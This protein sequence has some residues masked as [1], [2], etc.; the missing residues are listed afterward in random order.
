MDKYTA[1]FSEYTYQTTE[2]ILSYFGLDSHQGLSAQQVKGNKS[3]Y[4]SNVL[5]EKHTTLW[6][7]LWQ[8][9]NSL[10]V[11]IFVAIGILSLCLG[12]L[13]NAL[14]IFS[15]VSVNLFFGFYQEYS[16]SKA[17]ALLKKYL[18]SYVKVRRDGHDITIPSENIVVGDLVIIDSGD[19]LFA[20]I[21][22]IQTN[23]L[24]I[25]Q[26]VLTGESEAIPKT[27]AC[28]E[29]KETDIYKAHNIGFTGTTIMSGSAI[30]IVFAVGKNTTLGMIVEPNLEIVRESELVNSTKNLGVF[31]IKL[32]TITLVCVLMIHLCIKGTKNYTD[33]LIF[34]TALAISVI[35]E[36]LPIVVTFCLS[37]GATALAKKNVLV[38]RLSAIEDLGT[39]EVLCT[40]K[41]GTLTENKLTLAA[42]YSV[43]PYNVAIEAALAA[44]FIDKS[45][46]KKT[47]GNGFDAVI[48]ASLTAEE[49]K[50]LES[51][52]R[53]QELPYDAQRR[54]NSAL[55]RDTQAHLKLIVRGIPEDVIP[56]CTLPEKSTIDAW[57]KKENSQG[58]RIIV[59]AIKVIPDNQ[60]PINDL[61]AYEHDL[62]F[63]GM[64]SFSD[65]LK[66][67]AIEAIQ[68]SKN[69][70]LQ[71]KIISGDSASVCY[72]V[73]HQI[74]LITDQKEVLTGAQFVA[75]NDNQQLQAVRDHAVFARCLP[76]HKLNIIQMLQR[77]YVVAYLGDGINDVP[78]L[79]MAHVS[80]AV[81]EAV[82]ITRDAADIILL[83][84]SLLVIIDGIGEGRKIVINTLKYIKTT[85]SNN[86]GNLYAIAI[87]SLFVDYFPILPIH[88]LLINLLSDFPLLAI[89][90]DSVDENALQKPQYFDT[91]DIISFVVLM[92]LVSNIF[93]LITF[94]TFHTMPVETIQM[95]W[96]VENILTAIL[97]IFSTRTTSVFFKAKRPST[98]LIVLSL[99]AWF[100]AIAP[101]YTTI[102]RKI[103]ILPPLS[104]PHFAWVITIA[105]GYFITVETVKH[106][107]Y[108]YRK[109]T[110]NRPCIN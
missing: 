40:D 45:K 30:G 54:L 35:P 36:A 19:R 33:V 79:K 22:F 87:T 75:L 104:L 1:D 82:D 41:T 9:F 58:H 77:S 76:V 68:K 17:I 86:F 8:Q 34:A 69:L 14:I 24:M 92:G 110:H 2:K 27:A 4:G 51:Y 103:L 78:A 11:L 96:Y 57:I 105:V 39:V 108:V 55:V 52:E 23:N 59:V 88:I 107:Y 98:Q 38:K 20:D 28:S 72:S 31:L 106:Y 43:T 42:N 63:V 29:K 18:V 12:E 13:T 85:L 99:A 74:G 56:L 3:A 7:I 90:T 61:T 91:P 47:T 44:S 94:A 65:P 70:G 93:D 84:K 109:K 26:S 49:L 97:L 102:G 53:I 81:Q 89:S 73:A 67:T 83:E 32:I 37:S 60:H 64:L 25:D 62:L 15:C 50:Q 66:K 101:F 80:L 5:I 21:R 100:M 46:H 48:Y 16:S 6:H 10:F 95:A 71:I